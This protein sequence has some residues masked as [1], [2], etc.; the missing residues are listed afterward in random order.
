M[1]TPLANAFRQVFGEKS[2]L[3][4]FD[5]RDKQ[6]FSDLWLNGLSSETPKIQGATYTW[7]NKTSILL[8]GNLPPNEV[9][10]ERPAC[11]ATINFREHFTASSWLAVWKLRFTPNDEGK[12]RGETE[13]LARIAVV[14]RN[15]PELSGSIARALHPLFSAHD[16]SGQTLVP[17][18]TVLSAR[19]LESVARW[20]DNA[21]G[22][23]RDTQSAV[24]DLLESTIWNALTSDREK[25]HAISNVLGAF[26]LR[27]ETND[28]SDWASVLDQL[29]ERLIE[30]PLQTQNRKQKEKWWSEPTDQSP[31]HYVLIDDMADL[32]SPFLRGA[33]NLRGQAEPSRLHSISAT[34]F[35]ETLAR[36]PTKLSG[37]LDRKTPNLSAG[38]LLD[39][40]PAN[41][42]D[43]ILFLD[44]R[45]FPK[46]DQTQAKSDAEKLF[47]KQ[48]AQ[49]GI[50]LL[51][52]GR[53]LP[54]LKGDE[55]KNALRSQLDALIVG[56]SPQ[57]SVHSAIPLPEETLPARLLSL[58]DPTL[59]IIIFS[60]THR[61]ELIDPFRDCGNIIIT[62]RKPIISDMARDWF[63]V[64]KELRTDFI[65]ATAEASRILRIRR[66][67]NRFR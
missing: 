32:W 20:M 29:L 39:N 38:D 33:L 54:W 48:L 37:F 18:T 59:P 2:V 34:T 3:T 9:F 22:D 56:R 40:A 52:S 7:R 28:E 10:D 5:Y 4:V 65:A 11:L 41:V 46:L 6:T 57:I 51:D 13:T 49:F 26:L 47:L 62:F 60:S 21:K 16:A 17:R 61:T 42:R 53:N 14:D 64:V 43:F 55:D 15:A 66:L 23:A 25:H 44:L 63:A 24:L 67:L 36:L 35:L 31:V 19:R 58:L 1:A 12:K 27:R 8:V 30:T 45:L 50:K